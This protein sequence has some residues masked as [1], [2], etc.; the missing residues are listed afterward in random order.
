M[1]LIE[2]LI[3]LDGTT[4]QN[5]MAQAKQFKE[6]TDISGI[7]LTKFVWNSKRRNRDRN[8]VRTWNSSK[9]HWYLGTG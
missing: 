7:I 5:A 9:I 6:A 8:P 3:V 1:K 4:G 2:T